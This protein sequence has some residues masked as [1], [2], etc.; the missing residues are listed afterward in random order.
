MFIIPEDKKQYVSRFI[1]DA[2]IYYIAT[3]NK[4]L[5]SISSSRA[6]LM[7]HG[8][9]YFG[10]GSDTQVYQQLLENHHIEIMATNS[11]GHTLKIKGIVEFSKHL[12][13]GK[14]VVRHLPQLKRYY[15]DLTGYSMMMFKIRDPH[16]SLYDDD[17]DGYTFTY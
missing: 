4:H 11:H 5:A 12:E 13:Y 16:V 8:E 14:K 1:A 7:M 9:I 3:L 2:G 15:N 10:V 17:G 6:F